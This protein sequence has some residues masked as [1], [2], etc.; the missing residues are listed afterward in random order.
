MPHSE[1]AGGLAPW[2]SGIFF[3]ARSVA[4]L[5]ARPLGRLTLL[6]L[7]A[8]DREPAE[9]IVFVALPDHPAVGDDED[10]NLMVSLL[11]VVGD[12]NV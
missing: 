9:D 1:E 10:P 12:S 7:H 2:R 3:V 8:H 4:S 6:P 11:D 5:S